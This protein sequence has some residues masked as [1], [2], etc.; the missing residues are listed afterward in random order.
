MHPVGKYHR[1]EIEYR[2]A[3][4]QHHLYI[5]SLLWCMI[6]YEKFNPRSYGRYEHKYYF[7]T[8]TAYTCRYGWVSVWSL[9]LELNQY[10]HIAASILSIALRS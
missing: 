7:G 5:F 2:A 8:L 9:P 1:V 3:S 6:K 4:S 10:R